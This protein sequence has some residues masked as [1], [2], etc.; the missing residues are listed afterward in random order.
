MGRKEEEEEEEEEEIEIK[1][2]NFSQNN[3]KVV[4]WKL[5]R[6]SMNGN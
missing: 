1:N 5:P 6:C 2:F 4:V 3:K